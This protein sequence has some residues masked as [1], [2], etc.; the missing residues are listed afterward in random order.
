MHLSKSAILK[1]FDKL[2][3]PLCGPRGQATGIRWNWLKSSL[4]QL[5]KFIASS[6]GVL[7]KQD[8]TM[9]QAIIQFGTE[10]KKQ[11]ASQMPQKEKSIILQMA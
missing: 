2:N 1:D 9:Q 6:H 7:H 10:E 3:L 4:S 5:D 11:L 8:V